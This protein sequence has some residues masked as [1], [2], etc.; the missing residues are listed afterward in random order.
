M[1]NAHNTAFGSKALCAQAVYFLRSTMPS[2]TCLRLSDASVV[3]RVTYLQFPIQACF[4]FMSVSQTAQRRTWFTKYRT[5]DVAE[6]LGRFLL[7]KYCSGKWFWIDSNSKMET[8]Y[9]IEGSFGSEFSAICNHC[10]VISA[11]SRKT[12]K[13]CEQFLLFKKTDRLR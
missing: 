13:F 9:P 1:W 4:S 6:N 11:W 3:C 10:V 2:V 8:K 7:R 12:L 5:S